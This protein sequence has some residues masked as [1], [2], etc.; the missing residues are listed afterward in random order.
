[1][2]PLELKVVV[3]ED[4]RLPALVVA[5]RSS[6]KYVV[7]SAV[8]RAANRIGSDGSGAGGSFRSSRRL[9]L[10]HNGGGT[11][12]GG[13][14]LKE[15]RQCSVRGH[16]ARAQQVCVEQ[17]RR[18]AS[19]GDEPDAKAHPLKLVNNGGGR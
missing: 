16:G 8:R 2:C 1:V 3:V 14:V 15:E 9:L 13:A 10:S 5:R 6:Q 19:R 4:A 17:N 11:G 18:H 12:R 7:R